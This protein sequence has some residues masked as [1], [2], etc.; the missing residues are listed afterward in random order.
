MARYVFRGNLCGILCG[1]CREFLSGVKVRLYRLRPGQ[2]TTRLAVA[3]PKTTLDVLNADQ[4][5]AKQ[6]SLLGEF[7]TDAAGNFTAELGE[8]YDGGAFEI[9]VYCGTVPHM[10]PRPR[11]PEPVQFSITTLQPQWR[12]RGDTLVAA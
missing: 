12:E 6:A 11:P 5:G 10:P 8:N 3:D 9:D 1:E 4:I 2:D 7:D